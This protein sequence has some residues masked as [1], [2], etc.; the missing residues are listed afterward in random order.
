MKANYVLNINNPCS[1]NWQTMSKNDLGR[2]CDNCRTDVLDFSKLSDEEI[3]KYLSKKQSAKICGRLEPHQMG[4]LLKAENSKKIKFNS[5]IAALFL[6]GA[7]KSTIAQAQKKPPTEQREIF[8]QKTENIENLNAQQKNNQDSLSKVIEGLVIADDDKLPLPG[9]SV[10][11]KGTNSS[12][13]TNTEG[14]F[15]LN[16]PNELLA[17]KFDLEIRYIGYKTLVT[18]IKPN[19]L[20]TNKEFKIC[21][22]ASVM[23]E[24]VIVTTKKKWWKFWK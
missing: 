4:R 15:K 3:I 7:A 19:D 1:E 9:V 8:E 6:V 14:K 5:I 20:L 17:K 10:K 16:V 12:A 2:H 11:I 22:E 24:V 23:G 21:V 13:F 18:Q